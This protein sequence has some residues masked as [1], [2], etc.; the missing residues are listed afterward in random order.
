VVSGQQATAASATAAPRARGIAGKRRWRHRT[1][2]RL[3]LLGLVVVLMGVGSV[4]GVEAARAPLPAGARPSKISQ[5]VC[6]PKA[7][8]EI[9]QVIG[10]QAAVEHKTWIG[11]LYS[12]DYRYH[13]GTMVLSVKELSS[14]PQT[15]SYFNSLAKKL[16]KTI[17]V[18]GLG[19]GAFEVRNGSVVVRKDWKV[20]LVNTSGLPSRLTASHITNDAALAVASVIL[21]C[22]KGD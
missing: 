6:T 3:T 16:G 12:C 7:A 19:Q 9:D 13:A 2:R 8:Q 18:F 20:L 1:A 14:W 22:W 5:M 4:P 15:L 10:Q 17:P 21:G 11:H